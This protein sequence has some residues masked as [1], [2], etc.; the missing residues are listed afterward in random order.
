MSKRVLV[1][2]DE[3]G[4]RLALSEVLKRCGHDVASAQNG[5]EALKMLQAG[6]FDL[7]ISD[8]KMPVV[9]GMEL[10]RRLNEEKSG[11]PVIIIT[12]F[13]TVDTA[14]EAMKMGAVDFIQ[15]PFSFED[16][17]VLVRNVFQ[18]MQNLPSPSSNGGPRGVTV[19]VTRNERMA[20][21]ISLA[22]TIAPSQASVLIQGESGTGKELFARLIHESSDRRENPFV[23][24][25]CAAIP[26]NL[27]ESEL[28]GHEKG[29]F[30]GASFQRIGKFEQANNGTILLDEISEMTMPLQAKL[31]R[32]LQEFE[33]DRIGSR[34][35]VKLNVRV[36][37]TTNRI[38]SVEIEEGRFRQ[39]LYYRLNVIPIKVP[40]LRERLEDVIP[41]TRHFM[42]KAAKKNGK[43]VNELTP[44]AEE[45]LLR[46]EWKGNV[47]ELEN[48]IERAVLVSPDG[49]IGRDTLTM[50]D[51]LPAAAHPGTPAPVQPMGNISMKEMEKTLI[52]QTLGQFEGN[53][54]HAAKMLGISIRTLRNKINEYKLREEF[55]DI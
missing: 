24:V 45:Y 51:E 53:R 41:L 23:A 16:I 8:I 27:L 25:N 6:T 50:F 39:D 2:D 18:R 14:V 20:N 4:I 47:R 1:V 10:M 30:T 29:A 32:V 44:D 11:P 31:L 3:A 26:E 19:I 54:T 52:I 5:D 21:L 9:D 34:K 38:M 15:K 49:R 35:P 46:R 33:I 48:T 12:A 28:F 7:V 42:E 40:P 17:E 55:P 13:G 37:A 43:L 22:R 36:L